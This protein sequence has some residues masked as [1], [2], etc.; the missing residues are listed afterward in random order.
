M[1][2]LAFWPSLLRR[3]ALWLAA[4]TLL[5]GSTSL[6]AQGSTG[7]WRFAGSG[8][9]NRNEYLPQGAKSVHDR[10][11]RVIQELTFTD[12]AER[13]KAGER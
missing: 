1:N 13:R 4:C 2:T 10:Q 3:D 6:A 12:R 7:S 8:D 11:T 5:A 9:S